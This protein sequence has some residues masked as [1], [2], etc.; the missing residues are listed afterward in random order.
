[1][2]QGRL[3]P[4]VGAPGQ[5]EQEWRYIADD[6]VSATFGL[7][8]DEHLMSGYHG[9]EPRLPTLRLYT[10]QSHCVLLGRFQSAE[11]EVRALDTK[12]AICFGLPPE[13]EAGLD[14]AQVLRQGA[15]LNRRP[16][17]GGTVIMGE[18]QLG[19]ALVTSTRYSETPL[20]PM[21][22]FERFS[23]GI[24]AGL[25]RLG[26]E[27]A[28]RPKNDLEVE[29]RKIAGLGVYIDEDGALLFHASLL[30]DF[31]VPL[32]L[33]LLNIPLEKISDKEI[34]TIADRFTTVRRETGRSLTA[35]QVR[36]EVKRGFEEALGIRFSPQPF[37]ARE[38]EGIQGLE[39]DKYLTPEWIYQRSPTPDMVGR[40]LHKTPAG[41]IR[42]YIALSGDVIKS[43]IISGD[44]FSS[45]RLINDLEARLKWS[46]ANYE[47]VGRVVADSMTINGDSIPGLAPE[48]LAQCLWEAILDAEEKAR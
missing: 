13:G 36:D 30:V 34:A 32:M 3:S 38:L 6:G 31:D 15:P 40:S 21:E 1:M 29:G 39:R 14:V 47:S 42:T 33:S 11:A 5:E 7:A 16:T 28:F 4:D 43:A 27:A 37:T 2:N 48:A 46:P 10:Y 18:N 12:L 17:G 20:H 22:I 44:F 9:P 35:S 23:L 45:S 8:A 25:L 26:V 24:R 41:L 19:V